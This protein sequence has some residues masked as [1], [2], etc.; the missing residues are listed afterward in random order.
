VAV[1]LVLLV[2][3][4]A[5]A[6]GRGAVPGRRAAVS[7]GVLPVRVQASMS[8]MVGASDPEFA[9]RRIAGG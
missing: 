8:A 4:A 2:V 9:A 7:G 6:G 5:F 1:V 3:V